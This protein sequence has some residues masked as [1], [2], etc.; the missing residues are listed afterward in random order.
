MATE[1]H[2][3][4]LEIQNKKV[5]RLISAI[6]LRD[7]DNDMRVDSLRYM[8]SIVQNLFLATVFVAQCLL[9]YEWW[10]SIECTGLTQQQKMD[11][12]ARFWESSVFAA[13]HQSYSVFEAFCRQLLY[14][15]DPKAERETTFG[16]YNVAKTLSGKY[17]LELDCQDYRSFFYLLA[18]LRNCIHNNGV[19][20][21][22]KY[23][24]LEIVYKGEK[25]VFKHMVPPNCVEPRFLID[26]IKDV[27][28]LI[29]KLASLKKVQDLDSVEDLYSRLG[30]HD[31]V[32]RI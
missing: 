27:I 15:F 3:L 24:Q 30:I 12:A 14:S 8:A 4:G 21:N 9:H 2:S 17:L 25:Y 1:L 22:T 23:P 6:H 7:M 19:Y 5:P 32:E 20:R 18:A 29:E 13:F 26:T 11:N 16:F 31:T 28:D 10:D